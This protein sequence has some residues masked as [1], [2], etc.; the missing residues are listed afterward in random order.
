MR[1]RITRI[2][3]VRRSRNE[4]ADHYHNR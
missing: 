2:I 1:D 4:E 3:S